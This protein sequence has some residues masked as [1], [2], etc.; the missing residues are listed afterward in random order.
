MLCGEKNR[1][2]KPLLSIMEYV[3]QMK[4]VL[5]EFFRTSSQSCDR[6][7]QKGIKGAGG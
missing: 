6:I 5:R 7:K 1:R 3:R 4:N 2:R